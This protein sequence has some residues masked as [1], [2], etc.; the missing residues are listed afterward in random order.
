MSDMESVS[1]EEALRRMSID[2]EPVVRGTPDPDAL[3][4]A[5]EEM[6]KAIEYHLDEGDGFAWACF[7]GEDL[8]YAVCQHFARLGH[9]VYKDRDRQSR[10][11]FGPYSL[12]PGGDN[13]TVWVRWEDPA[14]DDIDDFEVKED[15][16]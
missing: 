16:R 10:Y 9:K 15:E 4:N 8:S 6:N 5:I 2:P 13:F 3:A 11:Y 14:E 12:A 1:K 7:D